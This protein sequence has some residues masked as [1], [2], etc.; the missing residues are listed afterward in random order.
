MRGSADS[1]RNTL[2]FLIGASLGGAATSG[3]VGGAA[4]GAK[5][6]TSAPVSKK[7][8]HVDE[9]ALH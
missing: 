8:D 4:A 9:E 1:C 6:M 3:V 5:K 2:G 7:V